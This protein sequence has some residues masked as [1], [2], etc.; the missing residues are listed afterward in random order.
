MSSTSAAA[1]SVLFAKSCSEAA[2]Y[3]KN[4]VQS[5]FSRSHLER[6]GNRLHEQSGRLFCEE[7]RAAVNLW[8][9]DENIEESEYFLVALG[10]ESEADIVQFEKRIDTILADLQSQHLGKGILL[11]TLN[12]RM[13][14][15]SS[16]M[17]Y[18]SSSATLAS[19][20]LAQKAQSSAE[21][22]E[23]MTKSMH[24]IAERTKQDASSV[25]IITLV[26]LFYLPGT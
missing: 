3:P 10:A 9:Y 13:T 14:L 15:I 2:S 22:M 16:L 6:Y 4:L 1:N 18:Q 8:D 23:M 17:D 19:K 26:T 11:K 7:G 25:R 5:P 12:D 20:S 24:D 21:R